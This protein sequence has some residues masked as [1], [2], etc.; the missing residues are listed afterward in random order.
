MARTARKLGP[1]WAVLISFAVLGA[2]CDESGPADPVGPAEIEEEP[3]EPLPPGFP[4]DGG[5]GREEVPS[6]T[7]GNSFRVS[8]ADADENLNQ[9]IALLGPVAEVVPGERGAIILEI[10]DVEQ[11]PTL[12]PILVRLTASTLARLPGDPS[13]LYLGNAICVIGVPQ[14]VGEDIQITVNE[15]T[16]ITV[17]E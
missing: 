17:V 8:W 5:D 9:K 7:R 3:V 11:Q 2:A 4:T 12:Q 16:E 13:D 14:Q 15:P 6:C 10:G 1:L